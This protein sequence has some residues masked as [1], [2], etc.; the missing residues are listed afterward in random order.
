M[1]F[2]LLHATAR[3]PDGWHAAH[4]DWLRK[5]VR[6]QDVEY[7]VCI[8][9]DQYYDIAY[10]SGPLGCRSS[11]IAYPSDP[12]GWGSSVLVINF[13]RPC[14]VDAWN[15]AARQS[16]GEIL[17]VVAD[18]WFPCQGWD[19][20]ILRAIPDTSKEVAVWPAGEKA[21]A[22]LMICPILTRAYYARPNRGGHPDGE[23]FYPEYTS[24][25][26]DD[27][28]TMVAMRDGVIVRIPE[29]FEHRHFSTGEA[30]NDDVYQWSNRP[31]AWAAKERVY[32]RRHSEGFVR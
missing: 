20:A 31:D 24:V 12:L 23:L 32:P 10:P 1:K 28:F 14:T 18:D 5:C 11:V 4:N 27:D 9:R 25:G 16:T 8:D 13:K 29:V 7:V 15:E 6:P 3:V 21:T 17:A 2:S 19:E 30:P 22:G 26:N